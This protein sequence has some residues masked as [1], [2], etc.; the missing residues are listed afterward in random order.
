MRI[1]IH[2]LGCK[3]NQYESQAMEEL[4]RARGHTL[5]PFEEQAEAYLINS[6]TVT[7][8][9]DKKSRQAV[10]QVRRRAPEAL[11]ALCGCYPQVSPDQ[12]ASLGADLVGGSG[13][14]RGFLDKL[15]ALIQHNESDIK[16]WIP[17][18]YDLQMTY[19]NEQVKFSEYLTELRAKV[20]EDSVQKIQKKGC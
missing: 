11:V 20:R 3:V 19:G 16:T 10:R 2:T 4:L 15:E 17:L 5:V 9:S 14:R 6:C 7:A 8:T 12:A 18:E 1:A 13:D